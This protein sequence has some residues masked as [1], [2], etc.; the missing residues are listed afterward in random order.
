[1]L[2]NM[3]NQRD[4][5]STYDIIVYFILFAVFVVTVFLRGKFSISIISTISVEKIKC[6]FNKI[7]SNSGWHITAI[8]IPHM[9]GALFI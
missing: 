1:M 6:A 4:K 5:I 7:V 2:Y 9:F 3:G 8:Q